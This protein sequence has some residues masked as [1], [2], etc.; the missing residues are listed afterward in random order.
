MD[1]NQP[2]LKPR[3]KRQ[4]QSIIDKRE[5]C[6]II[7][8]IMVAAIAYIFYQQR[9]GEFDIS[10]QEYT[11]KVIGAYQ[12][13]MADYRAK[14]NENVVQVQSDTGY[15]VADRLNLRASPGTNQKPLGEIVNNA[16][17]KIESTSNKEWIK[18]SNPSAG[19]Q[20]RKEGKKFNYY[21]NAGKLVIEADSSIKNVSNIYVAAKY[22]SASKSSAT[23]IPKNPSKPF[24][25]ALQFY[26]D[27]TA[28]MLEQEIWKNMEAEL[29]AK[30][31]DGVK[32]V[33]NTS[34]EKKSDETE[35]HISKGDFDGMQTSPACYQ[36]LIKGNENG[37]VFAMQTF[38]SDGEVHDYGAYIIVPKGSNIKSV[39]DLK[40]KTV[41]CGKEGSMSSYIL[42][43]RALKK[44]G[45][46]K[47]DLKLE[48]GLFHYQMLT[49]LES[50]AKLDFSDPD[51]IT[52]SDNGVIADA[53]FVGD[54]VMQSATF[55]DFAR[56]K[57]FGLKTY[58]NAGELQDAR[59]NVW[60]LPI[61]LEKIPEQPMILSNELYADNSFR[62]KFREVLKAFYDSK[63]EKYG[64][65]EATEDVYK[66]MPEEQ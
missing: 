43:M 52:V 48:Q 66:N 54:F 56:N 58:A 34:G 60:I 8:L 4:R 28:R 24:V 12:K 59:N 49:A 16:Q 10:P 38:K 19:L 21:D 29:R 32:V 61:E 1:Q 65:A 47:D 20:E 64:I 45:I 6:I 41:L 37:K 63:S 2:V 42:Q 18:I 33:R 44:Y 26:T 57:N 46:T 31:Y 25:Y 35:K 3:K 5:L 62:N 9:S 15:V 11:D 17:L 55:D 51:H 39:K 22:V 23:A 14:Q 53:A 50:R 36:R 27:Q 40:G 7:G 13:R 30:G